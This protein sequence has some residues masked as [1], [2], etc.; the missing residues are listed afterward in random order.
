MLSVAGAS[1]R[2]GYDFV[3]FDFFSFW[4]DFRHPAVFFLTPHPFGFLVRDPFQL[5]FL[6]PGGDEAAAE[7]PLEPAKNNS[8]V[9]SAITVSNVFGMAIPFHEQAG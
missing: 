5:C 6:V 1:C 9:T 4:L 8:A 2:P 3:G 7:V